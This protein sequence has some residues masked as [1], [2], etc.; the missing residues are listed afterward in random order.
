MCVGRS[1]SACTLV[2]VGGS[3]SSGRAHGGHCQ[4]FTAPVVPRAVAWMLLGLW[5]SSFGW[6][7][8][9][10]ALAGKEEVLHPGVCTASGTHKRFPSTRAKLVRL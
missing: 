10:Q 7:E 9:V 6:L 8:T 2:Q 4:A 1:V 5:R 3:G